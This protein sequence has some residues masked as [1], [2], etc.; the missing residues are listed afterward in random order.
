MKR[1]LTL[2]IAAFFVL[3]MFSVITPKA[4][5]RADSNNLTPPLLIPINA[6]VIYPT[7][8]SFATFPV[9]NG[10][11][12][13]PT[14]NPCATFPV[15]NGDAIYRTVN[16]A[17]S[18][19][20]HW[21]AGT[22]YPSSSPTLDEPAIYTVITVPAIAPRSD[23]FY[24][25]MLSAFD[26]NGSYD[27]IGIC[28]NWGTWEWALSYTI[29][30]PNN[31]ANYRTNATVMSLTPGSTYLFEIYVTG[32]IAYYYMENSL[33]VWWYCYYNTGGNYLILSNTYTKW[34]GTPT[35][36]QNYEEA[37]DTSDPGGAPFLTESFLD[38]YYWSSASNEWIA[39]TWNVW[40]F[41]YSNTQ[42]YIVPWNV[43][44]GLGS[45]GAVTIIAMQPTGAMKTQMNG[46][47]YVPT[48]T[49][50]NELKIQLLFSNP[51]LVGDQTG[52]ASGDYP[53]ISNYPDG[54]VDQTHDLNFI[55]SKMGLT[56]GQSGWNYMADIVPNGVIDI[57]DA[58]AC[59]HNV[60]SLGSYSTT[61]TSVMVAFEVSSVWRT[62][63]APD[64]DGFIQI[65]SGATNFNIT[66][67][68]SIGAMVLFW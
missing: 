27:Q 61:L 2:I 42:G 16:P 11:T 46:Y 5:V 35:N 13:C 67:N 48:A 31:P 28:A 62:P 22:Q 37:W 10:D 40:F 6:H 41:N 45:D 53:A 14:V 8:N 55:E 20:G 68:G 15:I 24:Y 18:F 56:Q 39:T 58:V 49:V 38:N 4:T 51:N 36:Y 43:V 34:G 12:M 32:N 66:Q 19:G 65:P 9:I 44:V 1:I 7:V 64:V 50:D 57:Y 25:V 26:S 3:S 52:G 33:G 54:I 60:G 21:Y 59:A 30:N 23:E 29:G 63:V 47:F 17:A